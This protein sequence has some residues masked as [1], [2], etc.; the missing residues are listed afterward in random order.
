MAV[1]IAALSTALRVLQSASV[2]SQAALLGHRRQCGQHRFA[3]EALMARCEQNRVEYLFGLAATVREKDCATPSVALSKV[4][5]PSGDG[6]PV[7]PRRFRLESADGCGFLPD[8]HPQL[9]KLRQNLG[10][11]IRHH[12]GEILDRQLSPREPGAAASPMASG[13]AINTA[14]T[15]SGSCICNRTGVFTTAKSQPSRHHPGVC[16]SWFRPL[17][18]KLALHTHHPGS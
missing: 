8:F 11:M 7:E 5:S 14:A 4:E 1:P 2:G 15:E 6:E 16:S 3:R 9:D 18:M 12:S 13:S 17:P 10:W